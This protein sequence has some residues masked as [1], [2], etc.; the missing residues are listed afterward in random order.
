MLTPFSN[1]SLRVLAFLIVSSDSSRVSPNENSYP[2]AVCITFIPGIDIDN[3]EKWSF[4][5]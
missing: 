3:S 4:E 2:K 1:K 5:K